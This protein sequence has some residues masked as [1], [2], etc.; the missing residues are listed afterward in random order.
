M[1]ATNGIG[2]L[3]V[4]ILGGMA[5]L[6]VGSRLVAAP[7]VLA[8]FESP[9]DR[10]TFSDGRE[11]PGAR[12]RFE[13]TE[14]AA[15]NGRFGGR[16]HFDFSEGGRYVALGF[17][18]EP[19]RASI[20]EQANVIEGWVLRPE[21]HDLVLR[22]TDSAGQTFQKPVECP[23][24]AWAQIIVWLDDW[25]SHW[26]GPNDG[27][28]RGGPVRMALLVEAG[29]GMVGAVDMDDLRLVW[30][31]QNKVRVRHAAYR[32][33]EIEG[34]RLRADGPMGESRLRGRFLHLDF[35]KGAQAFAL[36]PA[37]RVIPGNLDRL[38]LRVYGSVRP[39]PVSVALRT[40]FMTFHR[41]L[42]VLEGDGHLELDTLGPP[43]PGWEWSGGENDGRLHGP[44]RLGE[45]RFERPDQP[46]LIALELEEVLV[47][48]S[49]P[50]S[51]RCLVSAEVM[52]SPA[53]PEFRFAVRTLT[54]DVLPGVVR[55]VLRD[56]EGGRLAEG[57]REIDLLPRAEP[58]GLSV[59]VPLAQR[60]RS[61][62]VEAEFQLEAP[63]QEIGAV[64]AAWVAPIDGEGDPRLDP[65]SPFG[66]GAYF[67]RYPGDAAGL[68]EMQRAARVAQAAGVKWSREEFQWARIEPRRGEFEWA[69]YDRL[70]ATAKEHGIQVY[71]I[72]AYWSGWTKPYTA[73]GIDDYVRYLEAL[74]RRYGRE[75]RQWEIW[76]EPNIFF[77]QGPKDL[78]AELL[79][80]SY[81]AVKAIEPEAEVL[82][83]STAGIDFEYIQRMLELGAPFDVLTIHPYRRVLNDRAFLDDLTRV[84]EL[85][86]R[87]DG[88]RRP[89][90]LTELGWPTYSPHN[91]LSQSFAPTTLRVQ[92]ELIVRCYLLAIVSGIEPRTF[93][94]NFRNDG[95]DPFYFEHQMG[96]VD[97]EFRPKPAYRTYAVLTRV[98]RD[99][100]PDGAVELEGEAMAWAFVANNPEA[101]GRVTVLWN[102]HRDSEPL[103]PVRTARVQRLNAVGEVEWLG[104]RD[105]RVR[106]PLRRGAPVYLLEETGWLEGA[107][108]GNRT[109]S[110]R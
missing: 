26:G 81:A 110:G 73:E 34:W 109:V 105:G 29:S 68:A 82:G 76:N 6:A 48:S 55:W 102:P 66:M 57:R 30:R 85:V 43:G 32:F 11:F 79:R 103:V 33:R 22:L 42:G 1:A 38:W 71:A 100:R 8:D 88:T 31:E 67:Y 75:I 39:L 84:S 78:Y 94:Y 15:R 23:A 51:K 24:G 99:L 35:T 62:F 80:K 93:W 47:E 56:W 3:S 5:A 27:Q 91:T 86:R 28:V 63:G 96:I 9:T 60:E 17:E 77:W 25:T 16:L 104:A 41:A 10:I 4:M 37:D 92:A 18:L 97:R 98:L 70:V 46:D 7:L 2:L 45:I 54:D 83:L 107:A 44:L 13:R 59:P 106:V 19:G 95:E 74:V 65:D 108:H 87:P 14:A 50:A 101:R 12:G 21:G 52:E 64:Q 69:F 61:K 53:G 36:V 90:W 89:V 49:A 58:A 20:L 40:H 72:V